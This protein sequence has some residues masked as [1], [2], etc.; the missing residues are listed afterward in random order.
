MS[1]WVPWVNRTAEPEQ[2]IHDYLTETAEN[3]IAA[4]MT[5]VA[6]RSE[7]ADAYSDYRIETGNTISYFDVSNRSP[8]KQSLEQFVSREDLDDVLTFIEVLLNKLWEPSRGSRETPNPVE[9]VELDVDLRRILVEQG[10]LLRLR[11]DHETVREFAATFQKHQ[12]LRGS[13]PASN[14]P[15]KP[16]KLHFEELADESVIEADQQLRVLAK[17]QRWE[18]ELKPYDKAWTVYK[19]EESTFKIAEKLYNSLEA[20]L[21]K[22]CVEEQGWNNADDGVMS[23]LDSMKDHGLFDPNKAMFA[24]W[25]QILSGIQSSVNRT[26]G[27]R[28]RHGEFDQDY[29]LLLLHQVS[30]F[31]TFVINRYED[32]YPN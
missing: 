4:L 2:R 30:A 1:G 6:S 32:E 12:N 26:G 21:V 22:I 18:E 23:Y 3:R 14:P 9:L 5:Q 17:E 13:N 16:F 10:I 19:N 20:V 11:P 24:D 27:D 31:L 25:E 15:Q 29:A 7:I 28:K 8:A